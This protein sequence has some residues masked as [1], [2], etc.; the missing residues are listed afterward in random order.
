MLP[1]QLIFPHL[2][3]I[4][5]LWFSANDEVSPGLLSCLSV[6]D[7][8]L[9][10]FIGLELCRVLKAAALVN[11]DV[12]THMQHSHFESGSQGSRKIWSLCHSRMV[13]CQSIISTEMLRSLRAML[14][15][16]AHLRSRFRL[17]C[18]VH[19][20]CS[21]TETVVADTVVLCCRQHFKA[22][23]CPLM[24]FGDWKAEGTVGVPD[25]PLSTAW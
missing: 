6:L 9:H 24:G 1:I 23:C 13:P 16:V 4:V 5:P 3:F 14:N 18:V 17:A 11:R 25:V 20:E 2:S 12:W 7:F 22:Q 15:A 10:Y 21:L 8:H 19:S